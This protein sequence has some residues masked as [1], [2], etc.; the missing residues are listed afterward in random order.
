MLHTKD[1]NIVRG[2]LRNNKEAACV[3]EIPAQALTEIQRT[4]HELEALIQKG[5][6]TK[7]VTFENPPFSELLIEQ[8]GAQT[9]VFNNL[10]TPEDPAFEEH[11][12]HLEN[13]VLQRYKQCVA[14]AFTGVAFAVAHYHALPPQGDHIDRVISLTLPATPN[15]AHTAYIGQDKTTHNFPQEHIACLGENFHHESPPGKR[16]ILRAHAIYSL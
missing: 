5:I 15:I 14:S 12:M 3:L 11:F 4:C 8:S 16:N 9:V 1:P 13:K 7:K 2:V 10:A 6:Q